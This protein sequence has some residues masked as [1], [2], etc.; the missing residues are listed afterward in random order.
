MLVV[1]PGCCDSLRSAVRVHG[2]LPEF[3]ERCQ[4]LRSVELAECRSS[5]RMRINTDIQCPWIGREQVAHSLGQGGVESNPPRPSASGVQRN[6]QQGVTGL[7]SRTLVR[8]H[9]PG[10][11]C[12]T[13]GSVPVPKNSPPLSVLSVNFNGVCMCPFARYRRARLPEVIQN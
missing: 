1:V 4:S 11:H 12:A 8:S 10:P 9:T 3:A 6:A 7:H 13:E 5:M 2:V